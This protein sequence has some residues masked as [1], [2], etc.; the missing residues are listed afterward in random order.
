MEI[1]KFLDKFS[2][3]QN[4]RDGGGK[5]ISRYRRNLRLQR[6]KSRNKSPLASRHQIDDYKY[7]NDWLHWW[8]INEYNEHKT[9]AINIRQYN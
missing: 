3:N 2:S 9:N 7:G 5:S 6:H 4:T 8:T 1:I